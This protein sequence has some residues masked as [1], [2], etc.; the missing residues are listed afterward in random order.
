MTD[1]PMPP[2]F[3]NM[4]CMDAMRQFPDGFFDLAIVDPPYGLSIGHRVANKAKVIGGGGGRSAATVTAPAKSQRTAQHFIPRSMMASRR[5]R[6]TFG[7]LP[8]SAVNESYGA[9]ISS[10]TISARRIA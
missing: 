1:N 10:L 5:T 4:D 8:A 7:S 2:G 3:Y 6:S 9:G